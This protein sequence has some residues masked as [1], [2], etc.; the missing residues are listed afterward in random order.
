[1][2]IRPISAVKLI[3]NSAFADNFLLIITINNISYILAFL[4]ELLTIAIL[5]ILALFILLSVF[6]NSL[7]KALVNTNINFS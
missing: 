5:L 6:F 3:L 1:M 2:G 7:D 4:L